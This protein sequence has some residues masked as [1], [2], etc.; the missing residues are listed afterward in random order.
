MSL[1]EAGRSCT[2]ST[3]TLRRRL[4]DGDID[5]AHKD[6]DSGEWVIPIASLVSAGLMAP[7][8]PPDPAPE[9]EQSTGAD[10]DEVRRLEAENAELRRRAEVAEAVAAERERTIEAQARTLRMLEAATGPQTAPEP[11]QASPAPDT[12]PDA[13]PTFLSR[14]RRTVLG[15]R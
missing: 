2:V 11:E 9:P 3:S 8:S 14:L 7:T 6:H 15:S 5:G 4:K 13:E 12:K 10:P 1:A